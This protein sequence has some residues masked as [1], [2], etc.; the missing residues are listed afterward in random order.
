MSFK[1]KRHFIPKQKIYK[2]KIEAKLM[3]NQLAHVVHYFQFVPFDCRLPNTLKI[4][5]KILKG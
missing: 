1:K 3:I 4:C 5:P 2:K